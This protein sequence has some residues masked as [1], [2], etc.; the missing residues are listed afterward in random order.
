MNSRDHF[1]LFRYLLEQ[2]CLSEEDLLFVSD[3][4]GWCRKHDIPETDREKPFK[5]LPQGADGCKMLVREE[6]SETVIEERINA[7]RV[8]DQLKSI[9]D[10]RGDRL[11]SDRKKLAYLF[12]IEYAAG[13]PDI[14][15]DERAADDWAFGELER[16]GFFKT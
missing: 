13:L 2:M 5:F 11:N 4:S 10:D 14:G 7:L 8:R 16:F 12:L 1:E 6:I 3:I 15:D 9:A